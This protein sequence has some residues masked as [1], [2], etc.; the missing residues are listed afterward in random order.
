[1]LRNSNLRKRTI[2]KFYDADQSRSSAIVK[3]AAISPKKENIADTGIGPLDAAFAS[4]GG[5]INS[6]RS[7]IA[8]KFKFEKKD[9]QQ[10]ERK[11]ENLLRFLKSKGLGLIGG[12]IGIVKAI[13][14]KTG[15][16]EKIKK[17]FVNVLLGGIIVYI[18]KN[19]EKLVK[20]WRKTKKQLEPFFDKLKTW[21][22]D[23][24]FKFVSWV[25]DK[26]IQLTKKV[27]AFEPIQNS[28]NAIK[29][30]LKEITGLELDLGKSLDSLPSE[31]GGSSSAPP[32]AQ[33]SASG[34]TGT[35][36]ERAVSLIK[37]KEGFEAT[38]YWDVNAYRAGYGSDTYTTASGEVKQVKQGE[39]VSREDAER[40]IQRRTRIFMDRAKNQVGAS[41]WD[42][43][44][45]DVH[46][47]LT[48][49]AYNYGSLP[50]SLVDAIKN[51]GGD[52]E[53]IA[54]GVEYLKTDDGGIRAS[55][56]QSE[57]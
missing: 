31:F 40:D 33:P 25:V 54:K 50:D 57:A 42:S 45:S 13:D 47:A 3:P 18:S 8:Q 6:L 27:L 11:K 28:I 36:V 9:N 51:S 49:I 46:A 5:A 22:L 12:A 19:W 10:K 35:S 14:K 53:K 34:L 24:L 41:L 26:G 17:F 56:R 48:S 15:F 2:K 29:E 1:M 21:I 39:K 7:V 37:G 32:G 43:L 20:W 30:K 55:R 44:P 4:L 38:P 23:P 16:F 52:L